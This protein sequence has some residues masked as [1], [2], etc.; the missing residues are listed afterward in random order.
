MTEQSGR[1]FT[2]RLEVTGAELVD[3]VKELA[4]DAD[5]RRVV[6]KD[7]HDKELLS[8]P[9]TW[10]L[11]GGALAVVATPML[12]VLGAIGGAVAKLKLEVERVGGESSAPGGTDQAGGSFGQPGH[13][14]TGG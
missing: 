9:L 4:N 6:I 2:E 7:Q 5:T 3:R 1:T 11:A 10:G 14:S 8:L 13:E 12:A